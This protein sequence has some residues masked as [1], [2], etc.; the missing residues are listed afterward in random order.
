MKKDYSIELKD[1]LEEYSKQ[2]GLDLTFQCNKE[3]NTYRIKVTNSDGDFEVKAIAQ[4]VVSDYL[5]DH[6]LISKKEILEIIFNP[7]P[8]ITNTP[9]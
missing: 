1:F 2:N 4:T 7:G 6:N 3:F 5:Q 8:R 9:G